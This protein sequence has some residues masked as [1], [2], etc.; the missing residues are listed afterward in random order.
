[1]ECGENY[2]ARMEQFCKYFCVLTE[3]VKH[4]TIVS[5]SFSRRGFMSSSEFATNSPV[6][7]ALRESE[8]Q[9]NAEAIIPG[10][11]HLESL[12]LM[13]EGIAHDFN[14]ILG[15]IFG[16]IEIAKEFTETPEKSTQYLDKALKS[17][18]RAKD[19]SQRLLSFARDCTPQKAYA[20][21][22]KPSFTLGKTDVGKI[23]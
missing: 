6:K 20:V 2:K 21:H 12:G 19:L 17:L 4:V 14:N 16:Y 18:E 11:Q 3:R 5:S 23:S 13:A 10:T 15:C 9:K 7:Q 22:A 8:E 1:M